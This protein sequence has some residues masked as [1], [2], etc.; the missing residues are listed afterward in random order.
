VIGR[1]GEEMMALG[2][3]EDGVIRVVVTWSGLR[4]WIL[5]D[6]RA[7]SGGSVGKSGRFW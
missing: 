2:G 7:T 4:I 3:M 5:E 1:V 6:V